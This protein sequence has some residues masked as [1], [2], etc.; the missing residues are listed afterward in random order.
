MRGGHRLWDAPLRLFHW[1]FAA[2]VVFSWATG[3]LGG[4]WKEWH[5]RSGYAILA[6]LLFRIAWGLAGSQTARFARFLRGPTAAFAYLREAA[7][8]HVAAIA[9]HNP[10]GGWMVAAMLAVVSLQAVTGLYADDEVSTQGPL[11]ALASESVV[12]WMNRIHGWNE[13]LVAALV[14]LHL[15]AIAWY[16]LRLRVDIV[17]P[18]VHG[19]TANPA[20][21]ELRFAPAWLAALLLALACGFV[22][23][24]VVLYPAP[25]T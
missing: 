10:A 4:T 25:P 13:W 21:G 19:R 17:G 3:H 9:G 1:A 24:L 6:L 20:A 12:R 16:A 8:G 5:L 18:M 23:W 22:Y 2:L 11:S 14:V 15:A 7:A